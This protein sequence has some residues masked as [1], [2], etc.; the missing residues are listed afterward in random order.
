MDCVISHVHH[1]SVLGS[2]GANVQRITE[3][4]NVNI[5][6]PDR[7]QSQSTEEEETEPKEEEVDQRDVIVITGRKENCEAAREALLVSGLWEMLN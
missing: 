1:R 5:K 7:S 4:W 6:F 2:R 3:Q